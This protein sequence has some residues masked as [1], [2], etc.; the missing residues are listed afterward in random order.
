MK[1]IN[2]D[3]WAEVELQRIL[4]FIK[5]FVAEGER[6]AVPVSG[7]LDSDLTARL[8]CQSL[9]RERVKLFIVVQSDMESK[10]L[11]NAR[12]LS[13]DLCLPL[14]EIHLEQANETLMS[15]LERGE[16]EPLFHTNMP[17]DPAKAKCS[18]RSAVISC[19]QDKGF[20]IAGSTNRSE[21]DLGF[22]LTFGDNLAHFKPLAHLYKSQLYPLARILGTK[23]TVLAQ[24]PS[25]GFWSGQTDLEDLAYWIVN[26]GPIMAPRDFS[27]EETEQAQVLS[28][29]LTY[30]KIDHVLA[31][32]AQ[33]IPE[34]DIISQSGLPS[35]AA[36]GIIHIVEKA[37][38]LK[39]RSLLVELTDERDYLALPQAD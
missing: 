3:P 9:G 29:L 8:C 1:T 36:V 13:K 25:A 37:K 28:R 16:T 24:Q 27:D 5:D 34:A 18:V 2:S 6:V 14:T 23:E 39:N 30:E 19:Y 7:G 20:L 21:K 32:H 38:R 35:G 31:L 22:F 12:A 17:L 11:D 4:T 33:S 10:F 26:D 15:A